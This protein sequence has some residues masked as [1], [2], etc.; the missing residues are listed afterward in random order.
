MSSSIPLRPLIAA[1]ILWHLPSAAIAQTQHPPPE[2]TMVAVRAHPSAP[3]ID[4]VLDD[5]VWQTAPTFTGFVQQRP[6]EGQAATE[7]TTVQIA[8]DD[9]A[10][11][12]GINAFDREPEKIIARLT[13]RDEFIAADRVSVDI[14]PY[15]DHQT[16]YWFGINAAGAKDDGT[17]FNDSDSDVTWDGVWIARTSIHDR[18]WSAE[19]KIPFYIIRF[20]AQDEYTWG[21]NIIRDIGRRNEKQHWALV[22]RNASGWISRM[23]HLVGIKGIRPQ[24]ILEVAP[25]TSTRATFEPKSAAHPSGR[26][27]FSGAGGD[28]RYGLTSNL[29]LKA[30]VNP[31][32]GQVEADP[33]VVNLSTFE[34]FFEERRPFFIE[35]ANTFRTPLQLFYSRRIGRRPGLFA[36]PA[37]ATVVDKPDFT[38][39]VGA[40]KLTGKTTSRT[41]FGLLAAVT[42]PE[43]ALIDID[44]T[45]PTTGT[46]ATSRGV[47]RL[48]PGAGY[49]VGRVQQDIG[50]N[51]NIGVLAATLNRLENGGSAYSGGVD[52][53]LRWAANT[54]E[55][56]GQFAGTQTDRAG[57]SRGYAT[58]LRLARTTGWLTGEL[59]LEA[60]SPAFDPNDMGFLARANLV[61]PQAGLQVQKNNP[62]GPFRRLLA[63]AKIGGDW[64]FRYQWAGNR[65]K[66]VNLAKVFEAEGEVQWWNFWGTGLGVFHE[67]ESLN[68]LE[69]RGGPLMLNPTLT[70][71]WIWASSNDR[72]AVNGDAS[73]NWGSHRGGSSWQEFQ[74][75]LTVR[76]VPNIE[77]SFHPSYIRN[78]FNAQWITNVDDNNDGIADH[79]VFGRLKNRILDLTTRANVTFAQNLSLQVYLQPFTASG[80]YGLIHELSRPSSYEL[81]PYN[82][83]SFNPDFN[84]RSV[85]SNTV[86]RWEYRPGSLLF[87]VWAQSRSAVSTVPSTRPFRSL[88]NA[89]SDRG[90][91]IFLIKLSY[92]LKV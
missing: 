7:S 54:Y 14:N 23:G 83:L 78:N 71:Y 17:M 85:R 6:D 73:V 12:V 42:S 43:N 52:W 72:Y 91:N 30:T 24:K 10:L 79:F 11:Y 49:T 63:G 64:N 4:G 38:T 84:N 87:L 62:W 3:E 28:F 22:P 92:W 32:F 48:E 90:A 33:A 81:S 27:W 68:D 2:K 66:R 39:I 5:A 29:S 89:F 75:R 69:T 34:I 47:F 16:G 21:L 76:P 61:R 19:Y 58:S 53:N 18:G 44:T 13:R 35:D 40:A 25:Y 67:R 31:D 15:H 51:S 41:T 88:R 57:I 82:G 60:Y 55:F 70:G 56:S 65:Y 59:E 86:L 1:L 74:G 80:D 36:P 26:S 9:D 77:L 46:V 37:T 20:A 50:S 45:D 8:Y